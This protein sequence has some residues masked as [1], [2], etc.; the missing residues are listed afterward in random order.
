MSN[1]QTTSNNI[2]AVLTYLFEKHMDNS[3][4]MRVNVT[5]VTDEL[6][7][8]GFN[9]TSIKKAF[10]WLDQLQKNHI[11]INKNASRSKSIRVFTPDECA[12]LDKSCRS[13]LMQLENMNILTPETREL[14]IS[15]LMQLDKMLINPAHVKWVVLMVL[16]NQPNQH[17]ALLS[18]EHLVLNNDTGNLH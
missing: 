16:F 11:T 9:I 2:L 14:S 13:V 4:E 10:K 3:C 8:A 6:T 15:Q 5:Q 18:M 17:D 1:K 12:K 7:R